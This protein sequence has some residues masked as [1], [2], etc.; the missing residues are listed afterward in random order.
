MEI[1]NFYEDDLILLLDDNLEFDDTDLD[2]LG[3]ICKGF[4]K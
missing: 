2:I 4:K 1:E 3:G